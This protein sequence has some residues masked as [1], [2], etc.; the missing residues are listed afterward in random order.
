MDKLIKATA[1]DGM[2]RIIAADTK[3]LVQ[4]A[5]DIHNLSNVGI[6]LLGRMLTG[7]LMMGSML[8]NKDDRLTVSV[9]G[10]G[11]AGSCLVTAGRDLKVKGY[12]G[13]PMV[14]L[15]LKE[16][17]KLDVSG[18]IMPNAS[19][20][21]IMDMGLKE[22]YVSTVPLMSGEIAEDFAYYYTVSEQTPSA[23]ALGVLIGKDARIEA[24]GGFI[25]QMMPGHDELLADLIT[26]RVEEL[27]PLTTLLSEGNSIKDIINMLFDDMDLKFSEEGT[28]KYECDCSRDRVERALVS[29]GADD[30]AAIAEEGK[31]EELHCHFCNKK[32]VFTSDDIRELLKT[33]RNN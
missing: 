23:V 28:P 3:E 6:A 25:I 19:M 12:V 7:T 16:N 31:D 9:K 4:E 15:P 32:Y 24:S 22:P 10:D 11:P 8:K 29:I 27:K 33:I 20:T 14:D 2:V 17:G 26:Y 5:L 21:V 18:T 1:K 30:L 13:D